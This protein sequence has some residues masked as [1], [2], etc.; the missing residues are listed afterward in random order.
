MVAMEF[1]PLWLDSSTKTVRIFSKTE[2]KIF[3]NKISKVWNY[4]FT[5]I[6]SEI[7]FEVTGVFS[8]V[9]SGTLKLRRNFGMK[10]CKCW[11][12]DIPG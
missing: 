7:G 1:S 10:T 6:K 8:R 2:L 5:E 9:F 3:K 12:S 11:N 4:N